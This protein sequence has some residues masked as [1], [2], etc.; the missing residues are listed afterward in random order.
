[1]MGVRVDIRRF[2][3]GSQPGWVECS[4][5]DAL[6]KQHLFREKVP[7]VTRESLDAESMY[8]RAGVIAC[9]KL[10]A[11]K[12]DSD[13]PVVTVDTREPWDVESIEGEYRFS[14]FSEQLIEI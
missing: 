4:L 8:P 5:V 9:V 6:G 10:T 1:M 13:H 2:V 14:V 3:D 11:D 12:S 7:V